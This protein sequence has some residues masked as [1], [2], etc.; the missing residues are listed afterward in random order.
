MTFN[1]ALAL[2]WSCIVLMFAC[3]AI[4]SA[5]GICTS[6]AA[7]IGATFLIKSYR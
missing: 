7:S 5:V 1:R 2:Y 3:A 4:G 6:S